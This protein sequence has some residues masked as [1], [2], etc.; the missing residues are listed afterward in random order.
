M[1]IGDFNVNEY[2]ATC[3]EISLTTENAFER[4]AFIPVNDEIGSFAKEILKNL[5]ANSSAMQFK[6]TL[7][8]S[9][10]EGKKSEKKQSFCSEFNQMMKNI[11][12][13]LGFEFSKFLEIHIGTFAFIRKIIEDM[14]EALTYEDLLNYTSIIYQVMKPCPKS[15]YKFSKSTMSRVSSLMAEDNI[16][17]FFENERSNLRKHIASRNLSSFIRDKKEIIQRITDFVGNITEGTKTIETVN[18][19]VFP[20]M[21]KY[22]ILYDGSFLKIFEI[23]YKSIN[24]DNPQFND[25]NPLFIKQ[26]NTTEKYIDTDIKLSTKQA[27]NYLSILEHYFSDVCK[28]TQEAMEDDESLIADVKK[29]TVVIPYSLTTLLAK[30]AL[31]VLV[32]IAKIINWKK[33]VLLITSTPSRIQFA[34]VFEAFICLQPGVDTEFRFDQLVIIY[35]ILSCLKVSTVTRQKKKVRDEKK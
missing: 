23:L 8:G 33:D 4:S 16:A 31:C 10:A 17:A 7:S 21:G 35:Y 26:F 6:L 11:V 15:T 1:M 32:R 30:I 18:D 28:M 3:H 2:L 34:Q 5:M 19:L 24:A 29:M 14:K 22:A 12:G 13:L 20:H 9:I 25:S 27:S